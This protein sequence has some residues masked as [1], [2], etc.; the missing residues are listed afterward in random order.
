VLDF[1]ANRSPIFLAAVFDGDAAQA[2]GQQIGDGTPVH[3]TIPTE[4]P[5]VPLRILGL[6]KQPLDRVDAEVYLLT[7]SEPALLPAPLDRTPSDSGPR[8]GT[9][10]PLALTYNQSAS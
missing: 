3:I 6:G 4:N 8:D 5:W 7:D 9:N 1:Y 10:S 2:R